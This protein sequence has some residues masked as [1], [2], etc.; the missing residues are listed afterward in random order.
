MKHNFI[1][2]QPLNLTRTVI[3]VL[4][5]LGGTSVAWSPEDAI[6]KAAGKISKYG[7]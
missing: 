5:D 3:F 7:S 6:T 2:K 1:K 4:K